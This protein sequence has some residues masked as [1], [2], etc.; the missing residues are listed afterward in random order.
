[1]PGTDPTTGVPPGKRGPPPDAPLLHRILAV[2][3][4]LSLAA[5]FAGFVIP[6]SVGGFLWV[7]RGFDGW[8]LRL[9]LAGSGCVAGCSRWCVRRWAGKAG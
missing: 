6:A 3:Y 4:V 5:Q 9:W 2:A 7:R 8:M 1:M